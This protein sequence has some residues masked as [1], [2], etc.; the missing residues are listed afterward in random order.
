LVESK[1]DTIEVF[2]S[3]TIIALQKILPHDLLSISD[4][5]VSI[6][7]L[8]VVIVNDTL[9]AMNSKEL[10][11]AIMFRAQKLV[12]QTIKNP[13]IEY[14]I[15]E[16]SDSIE[17]SQTYLRIYI[18]DEDE[19]RAWLHALRDCGLE[20]QKI[21][22]PHVA[23]NHDFS[24]FYP[25]E[26][27]E[28]V[29]IFDLG[30][31]KSQL[32]FAENGSI[33]LIRTIESG[34]DDFMKSLTGTLNIG[35]KDIAINRK[36]AENLLREHGLSSKSSTEVTEYGLPISR[37]GIMLY[38][39]IEKLVNEMQRSIDYFRSTFPDSPIK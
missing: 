38:E 2:R 23:V 25:Q 6:S 26:M 21:T 37:V 31:D 22:L 36:R 4:V 11:Q 10:H 35:G 5:T 29:A 20:P 39:S 28:G 27:A 7:N 12:P 19:F 8:P 1:D 9:P 32:M 34:A 24:K 14:E 30:G 33:K 13:H 15:I 3:K 17:S 16:K 18:V